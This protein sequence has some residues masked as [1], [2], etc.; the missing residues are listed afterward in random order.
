MQHSLPQLVDTHLHVCVVVVVSWSE[1][2]I[3]PTEVIEF[4]C[5]IVDKFSYRELERV[6]LLIQPASGAVSAKVCA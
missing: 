3:F 5:I 1:T 4:G 6:S 2:N